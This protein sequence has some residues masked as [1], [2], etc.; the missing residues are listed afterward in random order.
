MSL[1]LRL[2]VAVLAVLA[3]LTARHLHRHQ[4]AISMGLVAPPAPPPTQGK[5]RTTKL[6]Q[7]TRQVA[8]PTAASSSQLLFLRLL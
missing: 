8:R 1:L 3:L 4:R 6:L 2:F 5:R 7:N